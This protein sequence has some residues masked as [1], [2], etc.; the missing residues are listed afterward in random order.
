MKDI[1]NRH[2]TNLLKCIPEEARNHCSWRLTDFLNINRRRF[3]EGI[4]GEDEDVLFKHH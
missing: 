2:N 1:V 4:G 3:Q